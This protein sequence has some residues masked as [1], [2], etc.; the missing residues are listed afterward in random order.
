MAINYPNFSVLMSVYYK[1]KADYLRM[2]LNSIWGQ[3]TVKPTEIILVKDGPLTEELNALITEFVP[4]APIKVI[5]LPCNQGLGEALNIGI[6]HCTNEWIARMDSD[7][8][9]VPNR[10]EAQL[11][12]IMEHPNV[13]LLGAWITE[14]DKDTSNI[15]AVK[16][17]PS[18]MDQILVYS[19]KRNPIN[20]P[21]VMFRKQAVMDAGGYQHCPLFEDYWLWVRML[22]NGATAYNIPTS[23][24]WFRA[25][26]D[27]FKR[28]GGFTYI[29][30]EYLFQKKLLRIKYIS[31]PTFLKNIVIRCFFRLVPNKLR[32]YLYQLILRDHTTNV[33]HT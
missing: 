20:H 13:D 30:H 1:E 28:R 18:S 16:K 10:F 6:K 26:K 2:A 7:D 14:F 11:K 27:M 17:V 25:S 19:R 31:V 12:S 3:Q 23:L 24:L 22:Q 21:V 32:T 5:N 29:H 9:S 4:V 33:K 15:I 8:I